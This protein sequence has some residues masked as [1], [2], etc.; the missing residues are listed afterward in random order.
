[1]AS[2]A[3]KWETDVVL[4]AAEMGVN[5]PDSVLRATLTFGGDGRAS[6]TW[7]AIDLT[8]VREYFHQMFVNAYYACAYGAGI[9]SLEDIE[10]M[11]MDSTGMSVSAY[12]YAFMEPYDMEAMFTPASTSG[13]YIYNEDHTA[14]YTDMPI[15]DAVSDASVANAFTISGNSVTLN[16]ASYGKP[17]YTFHCTRKG[18][19]PQPSEPAPTEPED[20]GMTNYELRV[21]E[22]VNDIRAGYGLAPLEADEELGRLARLKSEDM[23]QRNYFDHISPTYGSPG[24]MLDRF[25]VEWRWVG[26][27]IAFGHTT[28]EEV[29]TAW[30]NSDG[31]RANILNVQ[32]THIGVGQESTMN[33]WTQIFVKR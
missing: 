5:A 18:V 27:N 21:I 2:L 12:M 7:E 16:A 30:M 15:M 25:G 13:R 32:A 31:H 33:F 9:T 29:V 8:A 17:D 10:Q 19:A 3:G 6:V 22:L 20:S 11:C 28:P 1:M 4:P 14:I 24:Q 23:M 26:E